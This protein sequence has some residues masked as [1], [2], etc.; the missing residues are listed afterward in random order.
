MA[1]G[2]GTTKAD[3]QAYEAGLETEADVDSTGFYLDESVGPTMEFDAQA[4]YGEDETYG[5]QSDWLTGEGLTDAWGT[6]PGWGMRSTY[7]NPVSE[8]LGEDPVANLFVDAKGMLQRGG[9]PDAWDIAGL[10]LSLLPGLGPA[11]L[12]AAKPLGTAIKT[13]IQEARYPWMAKRKNVDPLDFDSLSIPPS[14]LEELLKE[15]STRTGPKLGQ[16]QLDDLSYDHYEKT[17]RLRGENPLSRSEWDKRPGPQTREEML[18]TLRVQEELDTLINEITERGNF[19]TF[20]EFSRMSDAGMTDEQIAQVMEDA[21]KNTSISDFLRNPMGAIETPPSILNQLSPSASSLPENVSQLPGTKPIQD[22]TWR[23]WDDLSDS[24]F[25]LSSKQNAMMRAQGITDADDVLDHFW[26]KGA[27]N[28]FV[29]WLEEAIAKTKQDFSEE[30]E[31]VRLRDLKSGYMDEITPAQ[32]S[33][34]I[35]WKGM[36]GSVDH[37]AVA[38]KMAWRPDSI[39]HQDWAQFTKDMTMKEVERAARKLAL[40]IVD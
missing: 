37:L 38:E 25:Q 28:D 36:P 23:E 4:W 19:P 20:E 10:G 32:L 30:L 8:Y 12:K 21:T 13:S 31:F 26:G 40:R 1:W 24:P 11:A 9:K 2:V 22:M 16:K 17:M 6:D 15:L 35:A 3:A 29:G 27:R 34:D 39:S 7:S 14:K 18:E 5:T 33:K